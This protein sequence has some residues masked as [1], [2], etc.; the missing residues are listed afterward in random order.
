[1][2]D[3]TE[4]EMLEYLCWKYA[5]MG[6]RFYPPDETAEE[7]IEALFSDDGA[8]D[9]QVGIES[10]KHSR[11]YTDALEFFDTLQKRGFDP[12]QMTLDYI[13]DTRK[14]EGVDLAGID[15]TF[16]R[17]SYYEGELPGERWE[18]PDE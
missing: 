16:L 11:A 12:V 2:M 8:I 7:C 14:S 18:A 9:T 17:E 13:E 1:M 3:T 4:R 15:W 5:H 6:S 10:G